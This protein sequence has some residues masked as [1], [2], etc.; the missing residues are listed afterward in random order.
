M[1]QMRIH[2]PWA[3]RL[4]EASRGEAALATVRDVWRNPRNL[5]ELACKT[6]DPAWLHFPYIGAR[7]LPIVRVRSKYS[8]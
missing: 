4:I 5:F 3:R 2:S 6:G 1:T 8:R 7:L